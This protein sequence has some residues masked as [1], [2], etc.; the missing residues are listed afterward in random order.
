MPVSG[1]DTSAIEH[2]RHPS[3]CPRPRSLHGMASH[4]RPSTNGS[5]P[6]AYAGSEPRAAPGAWRPTSSSV[7]APGRT[8]RQRSR[9]SWSNAQGAH[10]APLMRNWRPRSSLDAALSARS[11]RRHNAL[12]RPE[13]ADGLQLQAARTRCGWHTPPRLHDRYRRD[14]VCPQRPRRAGRCQLR[15]G[16]DRSVP[17]HF[18]P[19]FN[20]DNIEPSPIGRHR[21]A[22]VLRAS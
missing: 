13:K 16:A 8:P 21:V 5:M 12:R 1:G 10:P 7:T 2:A 22:S 6:D 19:L 3:G 20:P 18:A 15:H 14:G 4:H 17:R 9:Q 11:L